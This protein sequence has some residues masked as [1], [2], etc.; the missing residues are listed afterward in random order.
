MLRQRLRD[1]EDEAQRTRDELRR[2]RNDL[3][4]M[5]IENANIE[6][7]IHT[8]RADVADLNLQNARLRHDYRRLTAEMEEMANDNERRQRLWRSAFRLVPV[9]FDREIRPDFDDIGQMY[10]Q[11]DEEFQRLYERRENRMRNIQPKVKC[12]ICME[13]HHGDQIIPLDPCRHEFCR[14][15]IKSHVDVKL[16][17]RRFPILCPIC[18][19]EDVKGEPGSA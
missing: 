5:R 18:T 10:R 6:I 3:N 8:L 11:F 9:T 2:A 7:P 12:G 13:N 4:V 16:A 14:D 1:Q 15:C 17:E 19:A